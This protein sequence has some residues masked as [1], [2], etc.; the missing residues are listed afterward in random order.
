[1]PHD[2]AAVDARIAQLEAKVAELTLLGLVATFS[3]ENSGEV[4]QGRVIRTDPVAGTVVSISNDAIED[5]RLGLVYSVRIQLKQDGI[6]V[7]ENRIQLSP[8]M[9]V[10]AEVK[11]NKRKVIDYFMSPLK[12]YANESLDER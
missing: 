12:Q 6:Q 4:E 8:G 5:E 9:A 3:E 1:M 10:R 7:G 2:C 11:T